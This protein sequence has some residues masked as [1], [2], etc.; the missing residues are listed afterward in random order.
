MKCPNCNGEL[1]AAVLG[2]EIKPVAPFRSGLDD[3]PFDSNI[4]EINRCPSCG[5][6]WFDRG[7]MSRG[8]EDAS[9]I[10]PRLDPPGCDSKPVVVSR[11]S[12]LH[13]LR[14]AL[15]MQTIRS[16]VVPQVQY[17]MCP[18]CFGVWFDR[19]EIAKFARADLPQRALLI[20]EFP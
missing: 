16:A 13:C 18:R 12:G 10:G 8:L 11:R 4:R 20:R 2:G 5:G 6:T 1:E 7:E 19:G 9:S 14:C 15:E 3:D 17:E